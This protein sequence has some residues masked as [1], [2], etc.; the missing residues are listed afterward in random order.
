VSQNFRAQLRSHELELRNFAEVERIL[1]KFP[2]LCGYTIDSVSKFCREME[3]G[4]IVKRSLAAY[5]GDD[6]DVNIDLQKSKFPNIFRWLAHLERLSFTCADFIKEN[7]AQDDVNVRPTTISTAAQNGFV[8]ARSPML[9]LL[10]AHWNQLANEAEKEEFW[11]QLKLLSTEDRPGSSSLVAESDSQNRVQLSE[12]VVEVAEESFGENLNV[13]DEEDE[14]SS[15]TY[16]LKTLYGEEQDSVALCGSTNASRSSSNSASVN[17]VTGFE[18]SKLISLSTAKNWD[19]FYKNNNRNFFKDRHY[20]KREFGKYINVQIAAALCRRGKTDARGPVLFEIGCGVGNSVLPLLQ[21][22]PELRVVAT[23]Y[24]PT[25]IKLLD[26]ELE[27]VSSECDIDKNDVTMGDGIDAST[28]ST[29]TSEVPTPM[30]MSIPD[31]RDRTTSF[32]L[33]ATN[34]VEHWASTNL[35][36]KCDL[37]LILYCLSAVG[38]ETKQRTVAELAFKLLK[39]NTGILIFRDYADGDWTQKRFEGSVKQRV[40]QARKLDDRLYARRD[41][42]LSYFF[43]KEE[44]FPGRIFGGEFLDSKNLNSENFST[45]GRFEALENRYLCRDITNRL[46]KVTMNRVWLQTVLRKV[47]V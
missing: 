15:S 37:V 10:E 39:P 36:G 2:F 44:V 22:F 13:T 3:D 30:T 35:A 46:E 45:V 38:C 32:V 14:N 6:S 16:K 1:G 4:D 17:L 18:K 31:A 33:D 25:A 40:T 28:P 12:N 47:V 29:T 42:T 9:N 8:N 5:L 24:S 43:R 20:F 11:R 7:S 19:I 34:P 21:E 27:R 41:G 26:E 23:D